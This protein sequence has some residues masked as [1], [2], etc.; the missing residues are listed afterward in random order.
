MDHYRQMFGLDRLDAE[1]VVRIVGWVAAAVVI[2]TDYAALA[3][4]LILA[5]II[6]LGPRR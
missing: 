2:F 6:T 4:P 1:A 5:Q 3:F